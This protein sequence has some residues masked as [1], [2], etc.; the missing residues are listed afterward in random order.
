VRIVRVRDG[1]EPLVREA[2][3][4]DARVLKDHAG[5]TVWRAELA[6]RGVVAKVRP[7]S[8][9]RRRMQR[10][11]GATPLC[12]AWSE[13]EWLRASGFAAAETLALVEGGSDGVPVE[14]LYVGAVEG[15]TLLRTLVEGGAPDQLAVSFGLM[16]GRMYKLGRWNRDA[17]PSNF[18]VTGGDGLVV[19]DTDL[20]RIPPGLEALERSLAA[21]LIETAGVG[22]ADAL[23][24]VR[25]AATAA[26]REL[27]RDRARIA[28][29][30][31]AER[32]LRGAERRLGRHPDPR[33][34]Q[35]PLAHEREEVGD[36]AVPQRDAVNA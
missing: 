1:V 10:V 4:E 32:I 36:G 7:L 26:A 5:G 20:R 3:P 28:P 13:A 22:G 31:F 35:D 17:K 11:F 18:V 12:R 27:L 33:P 16:A 34:K 21:V 30:E 19:V 24:F 9:P 29:E 2:W 23:G 8:G 14:C 6:G 15:P 25:T